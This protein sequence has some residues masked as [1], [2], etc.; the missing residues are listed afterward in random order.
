[1]K[2]DL[3]QLLDLQI[4][5]LRFG[6]LEYIL[7]IICIPFNYID[8]RKSSLEEVIEKKDFFSPGKA[9]WKNPKFMK[10]FIQ[11]I[12]RLSAQGSLD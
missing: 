8:R 4:D 11:I 6:I 3:P 10:E 7:A 5:L 2:K 12:N 1:M 9:A